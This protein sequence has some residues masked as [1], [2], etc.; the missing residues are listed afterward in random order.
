MD[1]RGTNLSMAPHELSQGKGVTVYMAASAR[2]PRR[3]RERPPRSARIICCGQ[4]RRSRPG[5]TEPDS[6]V[7]FNGLQ[8]AG[9]R[10]SWERILPAGPTCQGKR[11]PLRAM[12]DR[13]RQRTR[14][15][16]DT[17]RLTHRPHISAPLA[18]PGWREV[19]WAEQ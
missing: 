14:R 7:G 9:R 11:L 18:K 16:N 1:D 5:K 3:S 4:Q 17:R 15:A 2:S 6:R 12:G 8:C 13:T 10:S 19:R